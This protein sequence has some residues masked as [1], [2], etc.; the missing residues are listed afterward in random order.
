L[1]E[2]LREAL[3]VASV[4]GEE[5]TAQV[6]AR[7]QEVQ[8]R[9][10]LRQLSRELEK[11][12]RLVLERGEDRVGRRLLSRYRF[13]HTL[14]QQYLY[15]DLGAGERRLL[16]GEVAEVLVELF[17]GRTEELAVQLAF[18]YCRAGMEERALP[19]LIEAGHQARAKFANEEAVSYYTE[20]LHLMAQDSRERFDLLA[21]RAAV[22]DVV[23]RRDE[24]RADVEEML[25]LAE[26][27]GD[28]ARRCDALLALADYHTETQ[29][30]HAQEP[31]EKALR[32]ARGLGDPLRQGQALRRLGELHWFTSDYPQSREELEAAIELLL[33]AGAPGEAASGLHMLSMALGD[34]NELGPA[35]EVAKE[36]IALSQQAGDRR[37]EATAVRRLAIAYVNQNRYAEALPFARRALALHREVGDRDDEMSALNVLGIIQAWLGEHEEGERCLWQSLRIAQSIGASVPIGYAAMQITMCHHVRR[38][39]L[40]GGLQFVDRL[41]EDAKAREDDWLRAWLLLSRGICFL[42][43]G[44]YDRAYRTLVTASQRMEKLGDLESAL[45]RR[46]WSGLAQAYLGDHEGSTATLQTAAKRARESRNDHALG[47]VLVL[48]GLA[49]L[50]EGSAQTLRAGLE[51]VQE[52][53]DLIPAQSK[54]VK[55]FSSEIAA[56]LHLAAG[57]I[58]RALEYSSEGLRRMDS[59][60]APLWPERKHFTHSRILRALGRDVEADEHLARA[61][62]CVMRVAGNTHDP[63]LKQSW[64][65][66]VKV[67]REIVATWKARQKDS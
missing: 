43:L 47:T 9:R 38:S 18:H 50:L 16:H 57:K 35:I 52:G 32:I 51:R 7:I 44:Q 65:E 1:E 37:Q 63:E 64:L 41:L 59:D 60:P 3:S 45:D 25:E 31:A 67:N 10:L 24:Q 34:L 29:F 66:N 17:E 42:L 36:S 48:W 30:V 39:D 12:H 61:H 4:E 27:L 56:A 22:Y 14:F 49:D 55:G 6:V 21:A 5:F 33:E 40:E 54:W 2:D 26:V 58:G 15:N 20:A 19:Y 62:E 23:A 28:E 53:L 46:A 13:A 8:E 11:R